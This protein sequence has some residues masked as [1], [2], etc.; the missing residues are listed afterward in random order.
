MTGR[1]HGVETA[2]CRGLYPAPVTRVT[3]SLFFSALCSH[4]PNAGGDGLPDVKESSQ[5]PRLGSNSNTRGVR[6]VMSKAEPLFCLVVF[7]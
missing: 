7:C 2:A 6:D 1:G 3:E 5:A 4:S